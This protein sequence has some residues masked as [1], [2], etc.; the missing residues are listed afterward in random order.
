MTAI[1]GEVRLDGRQFGDL[2]PAR[3]ADVVARVQRPLAVA[4]RVGDEIHDRIDA[5]KRD[6]LTMVPWMARLTASPAST[7]HATP[8]FTLLTGEAIRGGRL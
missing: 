2:M 5:L 6:Q 8:A 1:L 3:I 4:T 7:L